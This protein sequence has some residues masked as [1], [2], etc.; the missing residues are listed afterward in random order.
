MAENDK[1][2]KWVKGVARRENL[3]NNFRLMFLSG[4]VGKGCDR[5][6]KPCQ[7]NRICFGPR[8]FRIEARSIGDISDEAV[9]A[10]YIMLDDLDKPCPLLIGFHHGKSFNGAAQRGEWI[11]ELVAHIGG[12]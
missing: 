12:K 9:K 7:I 10:A 6:Q 1:S 2:Q 3:Q 4:F 8:Q 5:A 11:L